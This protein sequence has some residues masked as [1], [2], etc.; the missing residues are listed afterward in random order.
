MTPAEAV[1]SSCSLLLAG[2]DEDVMEYIVEMFINGDDTGESLV[3]ALKEF[4]LSYEFCADEASSE[5]KARALVAAISPSAEAAG[6]AG[7]GRA[8]GGLASSAAPKLLEESVTLAK[9]GGELFKQPEDYELG[10]RLVGIDEAMEDRKKRKAAREEERRATR[11]M[12]DKV[13]AQR[14]REDELLA[15]A[16]VAA[17][18]LRR[19]RGAYLGAVEA[20][21]FSM[22]NPGGGP[23]LLENASFTLQRGRRCV[24]FLSAH[25]PEPRSFFLLPSLLSPRALP[26]S[27][28]PPCRRRR[29]GLIGRN[30]TGKSTLLRNLA[31]RQVG[32]IPPA[33]T[34]HYVSQEVKLDDAAMVQTPLQVGLQRLGRKAGIKPA[35]AILPTAVPAWAARLPRRT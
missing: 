30:G 16:R 17:V 8:A 24:T 19:E 2:I 20:K 22:P 29:Y 13:A 21:P 25:T 1:R 31:A 10:G 9:V 12:Y 27:P 35:A 26:P 33:L 18:R 11:R 3:Q 6:G 14:A 15:A 23:D 7:D 5:A 4:I 32:G 34:I 28:T